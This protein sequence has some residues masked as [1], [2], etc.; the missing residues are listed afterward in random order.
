MIEAMATASVDRMAGG[1]AK[2]TNQALPAGSWAPQGWGRPNLDS[3]FQTRVPVKYYDEDHTARGLRR[4]VAGEG[5]W[6]TS[7]QVANASK[8]VVVALAFT[9][10]FAATKAGALA[11][12]TLTAYVLDNGSE[13]QSNNFDGSGDTHRSPGSWLP[14]FDDNAQIIRIRSGK[15]ANGDFTI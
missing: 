11:V 8:D 14:D 1:T 13:Y 7:P 10:R 3:L 4:F 12:S 9:D 5:S 2:K 6:T 15:I